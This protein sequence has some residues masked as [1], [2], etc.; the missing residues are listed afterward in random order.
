VPD[1]PVGEEGVEG[2]A[3]DDADAYDPSTRKAIQKIPMLT[4]RAG[5][6]D[7]ATWVERLREEYGALIAYIQMN[8]DNDSDWFTLESDRDGRMWVLLCHCTLRHWAHVG[9]IVSLHATSL[10]AGSLLCHCALCLCCGAVPVEV[11]VHVSPLCMC[12]CTLPV[13]LR[14]CAY[15]YVCAYA[16]TCSRHVHVS[17]SRFWLR[18]CACGC[19]YGHGYV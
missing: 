10:G 19:G 16:S 11:G 2:T 1:A 14:A 9:T 8:K 3:V 13:C 6:R 4:V 5:P 18:V 15:A 17:A 12:V 7:G